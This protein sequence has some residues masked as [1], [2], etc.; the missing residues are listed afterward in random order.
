[1]NLMELLFVTTTLG[2][3]AGLALAL[4]LRHGAIAALLG[5]VGGVAAVFVALGIVIAIARTGKHKEIGKQ[6]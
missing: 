2:V 5:F 6:H 4:G 1:M 3:G